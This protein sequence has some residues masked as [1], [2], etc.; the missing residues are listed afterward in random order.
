[1]ALTIDELLQVM[2]ERED[3]DSVLDLIDPTVDELL[4]SLFQ[5]EELIRKNYQM[6]V[7]YYEEEIDE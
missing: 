2:K 5:N 4:D 7:E 6:L 3:C 1:M